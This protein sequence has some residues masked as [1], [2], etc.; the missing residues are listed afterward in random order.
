MN[1]ELVNPTLVLGLCAS[2]DAAG[3]KARHWPAPAW[4]RQLRAR[5]DEQLRYRRALH[6][7]H[8]LD[9]WE[10]DDLDLARADLPGLAWRHA[11]GR[12]PLSRDLTR[13]ATKPAAASGP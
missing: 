5:C 9:D 7:L 13:L 2:S 10:L 4:A 6:E 3:P 8:R 12:E 1:V 11:H